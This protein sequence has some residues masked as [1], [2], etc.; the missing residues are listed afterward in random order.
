[1]IRALVLFLLALPTTAPAQAVEKLSA[2]S[3]GKLAIPGCSF[4]CVLYVPTDHAPGTR[5]PLILFMHGSGGSPTTWPFKDATGGKGYLIA[6]I[7]Y[8]AFSDAGAGGIKTDPPSCSAMIKFIDQV[9]AEIDKLYGVDQKHVYLT[10]LSMGGWGV[11]FYGFNKEARG[12][13]RGYAIFAAGPRKETDFSVARGLPVMVLNGEKDPN[14]AVAKEGVGPLGNAGAIVK[15]VILPGQPHVPATES[16]TQPLKSWL[17]GIEQVDA[18]E[19]ALAALQ[20][21]S[22]ELTGAP[23]TASGTPDVLGK[24]LAQQSLV[25]GAEA[26]RPIVL[27]CHSRQEGKNGELTPQARDSA[28]VEEEVFSFPNAVATPA[29]GR[30]FACLRIDVSAV[31]PKRNPSINQ[32]NA[33]QVILLAKDRSVAAV[34]KGKSKLNDREVAGEMKKLHDGSAQDEIARRIS[35]WEPLL[36]DMRDLRKKIRTKN[37]AI[38]KIRESAAKDPKARDQMIEREQ[39]QL[40][41]LIKQLEALR[42]RLSE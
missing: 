36:K 13:Y 25:S 41:E 23:E 1:M 19:K 15:Q 30:H 39:N 26:D 35:S 18:R 14:L 17:A 33:P 22:G 37:E 10:G 6:G 40:E 28:S 29:M 2:G 5:M 21:Q 8:G 9:R 3:E 24:Y 4:P 16:M 42:E 34:L 12:R 7:S 31:D 27:F 11:N 38:T 32:S 20:W